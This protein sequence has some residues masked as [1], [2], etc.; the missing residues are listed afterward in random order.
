MS[1]LT[2]HLQ[3]ELQQ[4]T[5]PTILMVQPDDNIAGLLCDHLPDYETRVVG[6][7]R[8]ALNL[9]RSVPPDFILIDTQLPDIA[10]S[11]LFQQLLPIKFI[12]HIPVFFLGQHNAPHEQCMNALESGVDDYISKPFDIIELQFRIKNALPQ[13][14][15]AVDLV[16]GLPGWPAVHLALEKQLSRSDWSLILINVEQMDSYHD[17]YGTIA[18]QRVRRTLADLL[19]D[20]VDD[21]GGRDD[22]V[23]ML[24]EQ[25]FVIIIASTTPQQMMITLQRRFGSARRQWYSPIELANDRVQLPNGR[26]APLMNLSFALVSANSAPFASSLAVIEKAEAIRQKN[27]PDTVYQDQPSFN[28]IFA[29]S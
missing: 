16:T 27:Q 18:G 8:D 5:S 22:F 20:V 3:Q 26:H 7:G 2:S 25:T 4:L 11:E 9:C 21:L 24:V 10:A 19:N 29:T 6:N 23:G 13:P 15:Q 28:A 12:N 14:A 1:L 17:L